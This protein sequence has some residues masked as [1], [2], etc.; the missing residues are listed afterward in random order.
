[1]KCYASTRDDRDDVH[2]VGDDGPGGVGGDA[3]CDGPSFEITIHCAEG[4]SAAQESVGIWGGEK[5]VRS[6][7]V[8]CCVDVANKRVAETSAKHG[9]CTR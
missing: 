6:R 7:N 2:L 3:H 1:M 8:Y 9:V 4:L 5:E